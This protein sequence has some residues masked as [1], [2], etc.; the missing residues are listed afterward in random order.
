MKRVLLFVVITL[1]LVVGSSTLRAD[2]NPLVG[3]WK[4]NL[5]KSKYEPGPAPKSLTRTVEAQGDGV[6]YTFEG[7]AA[8]GTPL[9]YGFSVQ[10][11]GKDN[12]ISGSMP[13]GADTISAKR[14]DASHYV[15][16]LKKGGKIIGTA[17]V[18]VS[19]DGKT[20]TVDA[21]GTTPTGV[22]THDVQVYDK[23]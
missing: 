13:T 12:P 7:V 14:T 10:F 23:Q 11:D 19:K 22:K 2:S 8:D 9:S 16:T 15:A 17:K 20:T 1:L 6:K 21:T 5:E 4:L 3:T 18:S